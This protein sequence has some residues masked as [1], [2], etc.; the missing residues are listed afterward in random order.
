MKPHTTASSASEQQPAKSTTNGRIFACSFSRYGCT[1]TFVSKNEWKRHVASQHV[2]LGFFRCD[3]GN[4]GR[5]PD[6]KISSTSTRNHHDQPG[7]QTNIF[8]RKD[9]FTQ[10]LR[11]THAPG[12]DATERKKQDFETGLEDV[13]ARCW[14]EQRKP[15]QQS[16]CGFCGQEFCGP[17]SWNDRMDHVGR[18]FKEGKSPLEEAEDIGLRGW[19]VNEGIIQGVGEG[20]VLTALCF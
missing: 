9:S 5:M 6:Y 10:H 12:P 17:N 2:Q 14:H 7:H 20:W 4:C 11:R 1:S 19:A 3:V 13:R 8:N 15:P 16:S 18:H